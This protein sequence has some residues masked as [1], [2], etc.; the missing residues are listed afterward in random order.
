MV[1]KDL[2]YTL[3]Q[4]GATVYGGVWVPGLNNSYGASLTAAQWDHLCLR[5]DGSVVE[6]R[7]NNVLVA[8]TATVSSPI[9][10]TANALGFGAYGHTAASYYE[11]MI[12]EVRI[13][14]TALSDDWLK[15][16]YDNQALPGSFCSYGE[17]EAQNAGGMVLF[18]L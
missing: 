12:D 3:F 7:V 10:T 17:V 5:Y 15:A 16:S 14:S 11:G 13:N 6:T 4:G 1:N 8:N 9:S 2:A 18:V